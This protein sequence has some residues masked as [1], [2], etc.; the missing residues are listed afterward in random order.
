VTSR[1]T[2]SHPNKDKI[3]RVKFTSVSTHKSILETFF[4]ASAFVALANLRHIHVLNNNNNNNNA[5]RVNAVVVL[6]SLQ[7]F[8]LG[9]LVLRV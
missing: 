3:D 8:T 6:L 1:V 9:N 7:Y 4:P 2:R 5:T